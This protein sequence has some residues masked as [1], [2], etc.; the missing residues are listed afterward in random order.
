M[1]ACISIMYFIFTPNL[2]HSAT[3]V[4]S[5]ILCDLNLKKVLK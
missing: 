2:F 1:D 3:F 4:W 5:F